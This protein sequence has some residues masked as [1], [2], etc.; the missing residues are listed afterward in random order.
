MP[1]TKGDLLDFHRF[2]GEKLDNGGAESLQE[3][4]SQW[5][6]A[7]EHAQSVAGI[8]KSVAEYEAGKSVSADEA[9][10]EVRRQLGWSQ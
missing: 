7:R 4:V 1:I 3:L 9:F 2:A 6:A 8:Q 5:E 10:S